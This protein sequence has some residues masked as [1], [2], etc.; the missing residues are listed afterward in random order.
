MG[1]RSELTVLGESRQLNAS[2][3]R[4]RSSHAD[5]LTARPRHTLQ[6]VSSAIPLARA[7]QG[8]LAKLPRLL[9]DSA[10]NLRLLRPLV[11]GPRLSAGFVVISS[12]L[13]YAATAA[14]AAP[15]PWGVAASRRPPACRC[16]CCCVL[17][18]RDPPSDTR[19]PRH[20]PPSPPPPRERELSA[21]SQSPVP[22]SPLLEQ[23]HRFPSP[24][25]SPSLPLGLPPS[26]ISLNLPDFFRFHRP[27]AVGFF[28]SVGMALA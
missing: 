18:R 14:A 21:S 16:C 13:G 11:W 26:S 10:S 20:L 28:L 17:P 4:S 19:L 7:R 24:F 5:L 12:H 2:G 15:G 8:R 1:Q 6:T 27:S 23:H 22:T 9:Q 3:P 25:P